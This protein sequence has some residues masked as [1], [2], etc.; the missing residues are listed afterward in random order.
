MT[1]TSSTVCAASLRTWLES[2]TVLPLAACSRRNVRNQR[3]PCGSRPFRGSSR[4]RICGSPSKA[5]ASPSR[6]RMPVEYVPTRR[7]AACSSPTSASTS[8]TRLARQPRQ[9]RERAQ[10]IARRAARMGAARLDVDAEHAGVRCHRRD[11]AAVDERTAGGR[12]REPDDHLERGR[13]AGAV[14]PEKARDRARANGE[15][16]VV[17]RL[18][19]S[20]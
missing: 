3:M 17:D 4:T 8:S 14:R 1:T 9:G 12:A 2:R 10:M 19:P 18:S 15:R 11:R 7:P 16:Q 20:P 13:L 6:W 5:E